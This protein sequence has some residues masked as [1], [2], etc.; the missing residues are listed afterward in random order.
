MKNILNSQFTKK[1]AGITNNDLS[2]KKV[3]FEIQHF[4]EETE[5]DLSLYDEK[6]FNHRIETLD[7][8]GFPIIGE[9]EKLLSKTMQPD[10]LLLL[11]D[12]AE[13]I[14]FELERIDISLFQKLQENIRK[15]GYTGE[16][17]RNLV[18][19]YTDF[20]LD[21]NGHQQEPGYDNLDIFINGLLSP[22][23]AVPEQTKDLEPEMVFYQKTPARIIFELV[24]KCNLI[25]EDVFYD[26][27]SGLGQAAILVNLLAGVTT[28]GVEFEPAFCYYSRDCAAELNLPNVTF[29]NAD[30]R[31]ADYSDGTIF[32]MYTPF[33]GKIMQ[34]ILE[35]LRKESLMRKINIITYGP[36]T[37]EIASQSWL[38]S[39]EPSNDN[40]YK[41]RVFTSM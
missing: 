1:E 3:I 20:N 29:I 22:L 28:K 24:E 12:R 13:K 9:I 2:G 25:K 30:A 21:D 27:G 5:K 14:K 33:T 11:K 6:S 17:F 10:K 15:D 23:Q 26:L 18:K 34:E 4:V 40:I 19:K 32:F 16:K 35:L 36:C 8:I 41:L 39:A 37:A 7:F 31:Q 38:D